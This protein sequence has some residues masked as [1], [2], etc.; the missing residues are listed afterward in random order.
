M[1]LQTD[2]MPHIHIGVDIRPA[3]S[4]PLSLIWGWIRLFFTGSIKSEQTY[5]LMDM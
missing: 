2:K 3:E 1:F 5:S 4:L